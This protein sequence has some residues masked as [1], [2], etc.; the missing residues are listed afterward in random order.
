MRQREHQH[1]DGALRYAYVQPADEKGRE[2]L[3]S[4]HTGFIDKDA[5][6]EARYVP[7]LVANTPA[8]SANV[9]SA[10]VAELKTCESFDF[11]IAFVAESGISVLM[12]ALLD[13]EQRGVSGRIL[14]STYLS[15]NSPDALEKLRGFGN[16]ELR[17]YEGALHT[18][19]YFFTHEG[20]RTLV[21][22]SSNLTQQALLENQEWN[23][24]VHSYEQG[25]VW[26]ST[27]H[28]FEELWHAPQTHA[29]DEEWL[30]GYRAQYHP[31]ARARSYQT[32]PASHALQ[33]DGSASQP[34]EP[35]LMQCEAL[36]NLDKL[37]AAGERRAL[38][39]SATGTGK[40]YLAA[41]DVRAFKARRVLFVVHR[42]RIAQDALESFRR[43]NGPQHSY[44]MYTGGSRQADADFV[45]CTVQSLALHLDQFVPDAF[46][47]IIVDEAHRAGAASYQSII[48][49]FTPR[50]LLGMT[51]TP[52]RGDGYNIYDLFDNNI[53]YRITLQRAQESDMLAPFHYFGI[54]DL[55]IGDEG[56]D[57]VTLFARLTSEERVRHV[58][59]QI[60][61]YSVT[62]ERRGLIFCSRVAEA[63][64]LARLFRER[65]MRCVAIGGSS[66][67]AERREAIERLEC[68]RSTRDDWIE[69]ILT[70][71]IFNEGIDIP[72]LNQIVMLRPTES[73]IIFVQQLGRGL[74]KCSGKEYVLV[75]D[76][77]G[78]YQKNFL[79]PVALSGDRSYNKDNLRRYVQE[80]SRII[81]G[82]STVSF[83]RVSE[84]R[85][86]QALDVQKF[87][88]VQ[89][90]KKEYLA[91][92]NMLGRVPTL[93]DFHTYES[94]DPQLIFNNASLG[95]YHVFLKRYEKDDYHVFFTEAQEQMLLF[96]SRKLANGKRPQELLL[97]REL[98]GNE[99]VSRQRYAGIVHDV[100]PQLPLSM[101]S[102]ARM[103]GGGF[104]TGASAASFGKR[105]FVRCEDECFVISIELA[106]ALR[107]GAFQAELADLVELGL[108]KFAEGYANTYDHTNFALGAK[109]T[110]ED[111][112]RLL[113][114]EKNI[115]GQNIG[116]YKYDELTNTFPVF[117]NYEKGEDVAATIRYHDRF[118]SPSSL[119]AISK[120]PRY[121]HSP[122]IIRLR[123]AGHTGMRSYLFVRKNKDDK[124]SKEFYF[125]GGIRPTGSFTEIVMEGTDKPAVE[126]EYVL[127]TPVPD[128]LYDYLT[129]GAA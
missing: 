53:A 72:S 113:N 84:Q 5:Y 48:G 102:V 73:A 27:Q 89:L 2:Y 80:G 9:L 13:A 129:S 128:E 98:L 118:Q 87:G 95:S 1:D 14:T 19:G 56:Q 106:R 37:R 4:L 83:D 122:E 33:D 119:I 25:S 69:Y 7:R 110:Y 108:A 93:M 62:A 114:W 107:D 126:I 23:L 90:I 15:F 67:D 105:D 18:K 57:D 34:I 82:C 10:L 111:V 17:I 35:N 75:L 58:M 59:R 40:T 16:V 51:A 65:G 78:N 104:I 41:L 120:Q 96:V 12:Q 121:L 55:D 8:S 97:L 123:D 74:R 116:G 38:L 50:F 21:I 86:Y 127:D 52:E 91:L 11:A 103:L 44:G 30:A 24:L 101:E 77:I 109:Y 66:S 29:V 61:A 79:I 64:E 39:V 60:D 47:Y 49:H 92:K 115:N 112:C 46:D 124:E 28:E 88:T 22:G 85:I 45:F 76:F 43:V 81:K 32:P 71:D 100:A 31:P 6:P 54:A 70:V 20:M 63:L 117:I 36:A 42:E 99:R 26:R 94:I 125:L 68:E 3:Y